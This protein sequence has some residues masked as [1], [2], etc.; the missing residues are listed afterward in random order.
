MRCNVLKLKPIDAGK[1]DC[2]QCFNVWDISLD[3]AGDFLF[4]Q[5]A[6]GLTGNLPS[7]ALLLFI[8]PQWVGV[9]HLMQRW[10][11]AALNSAVCGSV[12]A[13]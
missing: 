9:H 3:Y 4:T 7:W 13:L 5:K 2:V 6:Y 1:K 10:E 11:G 8:T 12:N